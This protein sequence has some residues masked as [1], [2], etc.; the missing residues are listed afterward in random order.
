[1]FRINQTIIFLMFL[2]VSINLDASIKFSERLEEYSLENGLKVILIEDKRSPAVVNSIW[3]RV[4]SSNEVNGKTGISHILEHMMFKGTNKLGPGEFSSI[5]KKMGGT[6][7]AFTGKDFTG[8]YQKVHNEDL[9]RCI[10][11]ESDRMINLKLDD[12]QIEKEINV[13]K[14]ERRLRT[15]DNPVSKTFEKIMINAFGMNRYGIPIIGTMQDIEETTK[16]DLED[17]YNSYYQPRNAIV[18]I[19]GNFDRDKVK[20]Y[21]NKYYSSIEND[22][23]LNLIS[24]D[25]EYISKE[26]F[27]VQGDVSKPVVFISFIKPEFNEQDPRKSYALDLFIEIMDGGYSSRLTENLVNSK[28]LHWIHLYRMIHIISTTTSSL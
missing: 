18:I 16:K 24:S 11:L 13:V 21:I 2:F 28:K 20:Q 15:D 26:Y 8:Y 1:M 10:E 7:N 25:A 23:P 4:G 22:E 14:E 9:E 19:A 12:N 27:E 5:V 6:D 17:W 3:Y